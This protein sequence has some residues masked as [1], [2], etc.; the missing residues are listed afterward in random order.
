MSLRCSQVFKKRGIVRKCDLYHQRLAEGEALA[1]VQACP[2]EAIRIITVSN[3]KS[4]TTRAGAVHTDLFT[5]TRRRPDLGIPVSSITL[6]TTCYVG[7]EVPHPATAADQEALIPQHA[8]W[9]LLLILMLTQAGVGLLMT[10]RGDL[11][12]TLNRSAVFFSCMAAS[13]FHLGQSLKAWQFFL[14][15]RTSWLSRKILA[16]SP[17]APLPV[18]LVVLALLPHFP[19]LPVP[20]F[21]TILLPFAL[22]VT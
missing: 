9:L 19:Q 17:F 4:P 13:V 6:P 20:A 11:T 3:N 2:T 8:H 15:L 12:L 10:A 18:T 5:P 21:V 14:G 7:R 22:W 16:F 1:C